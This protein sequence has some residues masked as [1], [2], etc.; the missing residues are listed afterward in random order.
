MITDIQVN[1]HALDAGSRCQDNDC[2]ALPRS[3]V[4]LSSELTPTKCQLRLI[5]T[6][7]CL[8]I[9][10]VVASLVVWC[11]IGQSMALAALLGRPYCRRGRGRAGPIEIWGA[12]SLLILARARTS[13]SSITQSVSPCSLSRHPVKNYGW[14]KR[15]TGTAFGARTAIET[16]WRTTRSGRRPQ[17]WRRQGRIHERRHRCQVREG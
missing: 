1:D 16:A 14:S 6:M 10:P 12:A 9:L 7:H 4:R 8:N 17:R 13:G 11:E 3:G 5:S 15:T 2:P